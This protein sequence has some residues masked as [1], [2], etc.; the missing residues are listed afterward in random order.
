MNKKKLFLWS[1]YDFANSF[2]LVNFALYFAP[3]AVIDAGVHDLWYNAIFAIAS[4]LLLLTA[5]PMAS[6]TDRYGKRKLFLSIATIGT[7]IGYG[8]TAISAS[9]G[10]SILIVMIFSLVG[11]YF[12]QLSF[13]FYN[14]MLE[15][16]A[17]EA[18]RSRASGIGQFASNIGFVLGILVTLPLSGSRLAP[19]LPA[20]I[21]FFIFAL[22]LM[23]FFKEEKRPPA[24]SQTAKERAYHLRKLARF[25]AVS[26]AAPMLIAFFFFNDALITI[27]NNYSIYLERVF[28]VSDMTK[29]VLLMAIL[30]MS[31][32]GGVLA[33]W[34]G[35]KIGALRTLKLIL[36]AWVILI[37]LIAIAPNFAAITV[38]TPLSG[39]LLG[40]IWTVTRSYLT[41]VLPKEDMGYGFSFY[42]LAERFSTLV[43]PLTWGGILWHFGTEGVYYRYAMISMTVFLVL[44]LVILLAW[45]RPVPTSA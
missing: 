34:L 7:F 11:Q 23:L 4:L 44:G 17:D 6:Y 35:D 20:V 31:A 30:A 22:P 1:L 13:V 39:L 25:F 15:D 40:A 32:V 10:L 14:P 12:Y 18:H 27:S 24:P 36:L 2:I 28:G 42:T 26:A 29:S 43:G 38:L 16:V 45:K 3:W 5:P 8:L 9:A 19:L 37:P 41:M 21:I 33:G